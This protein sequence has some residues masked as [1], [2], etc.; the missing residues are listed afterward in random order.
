VLS[1]TSGDL[2][3]D[4]DDATAVTLS[5]ITSPEGKPLKRLS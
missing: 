2:E 1:N 4:P 5:P 3:P